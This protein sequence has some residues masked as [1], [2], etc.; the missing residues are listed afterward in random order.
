MKSNQYTNYLLIIL[1]ILFYS[2]K[3]FG[4][5]EFQDI[6]DSGEYLYAYSIEINEAIYG[7]SN[8]RV[9]IDMVFLEII[10]K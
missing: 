6:V 5:S 3:I 10:Q 2:P 7:I 8:K 1:F 9:S 4:N